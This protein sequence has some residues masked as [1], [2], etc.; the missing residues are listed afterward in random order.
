[1]PELTP[2]EKAMVDSIPAAIIPPCETKLFAWNKWSLFHLFSSVI[3]KIEG[4]IHALCDTVGICSHQKGGPS[5][6]DQVLN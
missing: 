3:D 6:W 1:M 5:S 2:E 4:S